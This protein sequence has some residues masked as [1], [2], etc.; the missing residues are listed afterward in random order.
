[1]ALISHTHKFVYIKN[2]KVAST[3]VEMFF[4]P[5]TYENPA[6]HISI[7]RR[8]FKGDE[9]GVVAGRPSRLNPGPLRAHDGLQKVLHYLKAK[10]YNEKNYFKFC[11]VRNPFDRLV[12]EYLFDQRLSR[13]YA[14]NGFKSYIKQY[15]NNF[16][17]RLTVNRE[18]AMDYFI[19]FED[20]HAGIKEVCEKVNI[21]DYDL[22]KLSS[23]AAYRTDPVTKVIAPRRHYREFYEEAEGTRTQVERL[24]KWELK[25][26]GYEY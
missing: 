19:R 3:S 24:C 11:V 17:S 16:R 9:H 23:G 5:Y 18:L 22:A 26:F 8:P 10:G 15:R 7:Q 4:E 1:M 2:I 20:L 25:Y 21:T 13:H 12:S 6:D 14:M